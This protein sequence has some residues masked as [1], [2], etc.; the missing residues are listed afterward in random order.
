MRPKSTQNGSKIHEKWVPKVNAK[1][2]LF[3][4][5]FRY[6]FSLISKPPSKQ[7]SFKTLWGVLEIGLRVCTTSIATEDGLEADFR[8]QNPS[9]IGPK[10]CSKPF[11]RSLWGSFWGVGACLRLRKQPKSEKLQKP[12][13]FTAFWAPQ[14]VRLHGL[15]TVNWLILGP[16]MHPKSIQNGSK[17]HQKWVP[18]ADA[19]LKLFRCQFRFDFSLIS[20]PPTK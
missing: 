19:K 14:D 11:W 8:C 10:C 2:K 9:K 18:K 15:R 6:D 7:K 16:Q 12:S 5:Q 1:L 4:Y 17:I 3:R 13:V 20:K